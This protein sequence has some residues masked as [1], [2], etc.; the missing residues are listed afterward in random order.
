MQEREPETYKSMSTLELK[1]A[2]WKYEEFIEFIDALQI[3]DYTPEEY[4]HLPAFKKYFLDWD[5]IDPD[6]NNPKVNVAQYVYELDNL[7]REEQ[8][9]QARVSKDRSAILN[10]LNTPLLSR[11]IAYVWGLKENGR[12]G[13]PDVAATVIVDERRTRMAEDIMRSTTNAANRGG[14]YIK[15]LNLKGNDLSLDM[16]AGRLGGNQALTEQVIKQREHD[17]DSPEKPDEEDEDIKP[18]KFDK[19]GLDAMEIDKDEDEKEEEEERKKA[20][21]RFGG[22]KVELEKNTSKKSVLPRQSKVNDSVNKSN[23]SAIQKTNLTALTQDDAGPKDQEKYS[24]VKPLYLPGTEITKITCGNAFTVA[25]DAS[26]RVWAWGKGADG[27]LGNGVL[28]DLY[29]PRSPLPSSFFQTQ[30]NP[31]GKVYDIAA[32]SQ[33]VLAITK[34]G[35]LV[36]WGKGLHGRLGHGNDMSQL[37][38]TKVNFFTSEKEALRVILIAAGDQHSACVTNKKEIYTWGCG[39]NYRLGHGV[40]F[41][42]L[43]PRKVTALED[44][45]T[46]FI[47]CGS[48]HTACITNEGSIYAWGSGLNGRLGCETKIGIDAKVPTKVGQLYSDI[49]KIIFK[50]VAAGPSHTLGVSE[51]GDLYAWGSYKFH[52]LGLL[53]VYQDINVPTKVPG[54]YYNPELE[55]EKRQNMLQEGD[56]DENDFAFAKKT[57]VNPANIYDLEYQKRILENHKKKILAP[58]IIRVFCGESN[59]AFLTEGGDVF[60]TGSGK[61][62]ELGINPDDDKQNDDSDEEDRD[63][64]RTKD[65]FF[66]M[67][68]RHLVLSATTKFKHLAIG[69]G[70]IVGITLSGRAYAWGCNTN[71]QLGLGKLEKFFFVPQLV[72]GLSAKDNVM[73]ACGPNFSAVLNQSGEIWVFGTAEYGCL[74]LIENKLVYDAS[75]PKMIN[76]IEPMKHIACGSQHMASISHDGRIFSW[77]N[78][79]NGRLGNGTKSTIFKPEEVKV[80][81]GTEL[82]KFKQIGCGRLHTLALDSEGNVWGTGLKQYAGLDFQNDKEMGEVNA[83]KKIEFRE[84]KRF[85]HISVGEYHNIALSV[86]EKEGESGETWGWG[87]MDYGQLGPENKINITENQ[88]KIGNISGPKKIEVSQ[89]DD[90]PFG[91][92]EYVAAGVN[93]SALSTSEGQVFVWGCGLSGRLGIST[94]EIIE[95]SKHGKI[96]NEKSVMTL[97]TPYK[98]NY[99]FE[100]GEIL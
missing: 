73:A 97:G 82:V 89:Q 90:D 47:S 72:E 9:A 77:G 3:D 43:L 59:T 56:D 32:G 20:R 80:M 55:Y 33:H 74:G 27:C 40:N 54:K 5:E 42:E 81:N 46:L 10:E 65:T 26:G 62:G 79:Q 35:T 61:N 23:I 83:F 2:I 88:S 41:D 13:L 48:L 96:K 21:Q 44:V 31:D 12:L 92:I 94:D 36:S 50:Q 67:V 29:E 52:V 14:S 58:G 70:H 57:R 64:I 15:G 51:R 69:S 91:T 1:D 37:Y 34:D 16:K 85:K 68:P 11:H 8:E 4:R 98:I 53:D 76:D 99:K 28:F 45:D 78:G 38:P 7:V 84:R 22:V 25:L 95:L 75:T 66:S 49:K 39:A 30:K 100:E 6:T 19:K 63:V 93:H 86:P 18:K 24:P 87:K 60:I 71:S 17:D